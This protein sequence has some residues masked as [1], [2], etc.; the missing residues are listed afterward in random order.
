MAG[1][2]CLLLMLWLKISSWEMMLIVFP[3]P[4]MKVKRATALGGALGGRG[5]EGE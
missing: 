3:P 1:G 5:Q 4:T 2:L